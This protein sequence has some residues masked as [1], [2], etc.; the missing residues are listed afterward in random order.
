MTAT[1]AHREYSDDISV[2]E[3]NRQSVPALRPYLRDLLDRREFI[4]E[5]ATAEVRG[6]RSS[7]VMGELWALLDPLFQAAIYFFLFRR[8]V[9]DK[10]KPHWREET[11]T[12]PGE[13]SA[14]APVTAP[15][16][17]TT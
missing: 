5:L 4:V 1:A 16:A 14:A 9:Q 3:P 6:Q 17:A 7:M 12:M 11:P 10:E 13:E 15:G 8:M 2:F